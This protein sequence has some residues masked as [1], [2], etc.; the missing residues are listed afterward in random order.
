MRFEPQ[1]NQVYVIGAAGY[2]LA[3]W[4]GAR[5]P[6]LGTHFDNWRERKPV[7]SKPRKTRA[8]VSARQVTI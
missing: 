1:L 2:W 6:S 5:Q 7:K 4:K 8:G 3:L